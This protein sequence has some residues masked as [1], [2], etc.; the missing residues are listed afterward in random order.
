MTLTLFLSATVP[1]SGC[2]R[3]SLCEHIEE[4]GVCVICNEIVDAKA[5]LVRYV[6]ENGKK[7]A[8]NGYEI[9][10]TALGT[11]EKWTV[12]IEF[13]CEREEIVF[14]GR[15]ETGLFT[16]FITMDLDFGNNEK[17]VSMLVEIGR[18]AFVA[19][20]SIY[21]DTFHCERACVYDFQCRHGEISA[22]LQSELESNISF[23]LLKS[24]EKL[25][26][27]NTGVT[28]AMLGFKKVKV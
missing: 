5:V 19:S 14:S 21:A 11:E 25:Q 8:K 7:S 22:F 28:M 2:N 3:R 13:D 23:M 4:E 6:I 15:K 16:D 24:A 10:K 1:F 12:R 20:G 18:D 26:E 9:T 17:R 27:T